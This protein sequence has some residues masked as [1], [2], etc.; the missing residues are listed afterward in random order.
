MSADGVTPAGRPCATV[1]VLAPWQLVPP[2]EL[3]FW[4]LPTLNTACACAGRGAHASPTIAS[5]TMARSCCLLIGFY[6]S[7]CDP[8]I[9]ATMGPCHVLFPWRSTSSSQYCTGPSSVGVVASDHE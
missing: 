5:V 8:A 6:R 4:K 9:P 7:L 3:H 1:L 2:C